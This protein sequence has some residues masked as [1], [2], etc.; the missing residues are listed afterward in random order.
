[1]AK[2]NN[3]RDRL[4]LKVAG[5]QQTVKAMEAD[6][7]WIKRELRKRPVVKGAEK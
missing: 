5:I 1:M 2:K 7:R 3:P 4:A 6:I